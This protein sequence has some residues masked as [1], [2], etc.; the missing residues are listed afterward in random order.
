MR[1]R[2][3]FT[4]VALIGFVVGFT[5]DGAARASRADRTV[6]P[7]I[8][9]VAPTPLK[10]AKAAQALTITGSG[11]A[12]GLTLMVTTP[13]GQSQRFTAGD[14]KSA[15]ET[16][17]EV[18]ILLSTAGTYSLVVTN[19][20]GDASEP[21]ALT[22][23]SAGGAGPRIDRTQPDHATRDPQPQVIKLV[24]QNFA[25]G[26]SITV[27]DPIGTATV[28][29]GSAVGDVT[30]ATATLSVVLDKSGQYSIMITNP[31]GESSNAVSL[32]VAVPVGQRRHNK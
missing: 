3:I 13:G 32:D 15:R 7:H 2:S 16:S 20:N 4:C 21:F 29:A 28:I 17:F 10:P 31:T 18:S 6:A 11:F 1:L 24:G 30:P 14:V 9:S 27:T 8:T 12:S 23:G 5:L 25:A 19:P 22:V 26:L